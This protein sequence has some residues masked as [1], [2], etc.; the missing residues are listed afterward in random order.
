M[1]R[2]PKKHGRQLVV[3]PQR[4]SPSELCETA[5]IQTKSRAVPP[6]Q[7]SDMPQQRQVEKTKGAAEIGLPSFEAQLV[8]DMSLIA[9][10]RAFALNSHHSCADSM[11]SSMNDSAAFASACSMHSHG[12]KPLVHC[13]PVHCGDDQFLAEP[14][15]PTSFSHRPLSGNDSHTSFLASIVSSR[16]SRRSS[17][18]STS[19]LAAQRRAH[20]DTAPV[21]LGN[22]SVIRH[23]TK[24]REKRMIKAA[25]SQ[26]N[27]RSSSVASC[28]REA[29]PSSPT[30]HQHRLSEF[31]ILKSCSSAVSRICSA[32]SRE[33]S[34]GK[35]T[36]RETGAAVT[37][38]PCAAN[39]PYIGHAE[40]EA[41]VRATEGLKM[42]GRNTQEDHLPISVDSHQR[43]GATSGGGGAR[44]GSSRASSHHAPFDEA[45]SDLPSLCSER[46]MN[47]MFSGVLLD[48]E[49]D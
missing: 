29:A 9:T 4:L 24:K 36:H 45:L 22:P 16:A 6:S 21:A 15:S 23:L 30:E 43:G 14:A 47:D 48:N 10:P 5:P 17:C 2:S 20:N 44:W 11:A 13:V 40:E 8:P 32:A 3:T 28:N 35:Q 41:D 1:G 39:L 7:M 26:A 25:K 33:S 31:P 18:S 42:V 27:S 38:V 46:S 19:S 37:A 34:R 12:A 49:R